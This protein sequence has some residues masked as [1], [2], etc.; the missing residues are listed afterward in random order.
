MRHTLKEQACFAYP[1]FGTVHKPGGISNTKVGE[2]YTGDS[3]RG[4]DVAVHAVASIHSISAAI[5]M[6]FC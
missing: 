4:R 6:T 1:S 3:H 2:Y 5:P